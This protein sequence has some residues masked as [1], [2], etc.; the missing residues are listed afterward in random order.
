[1]AGN[2]EKK[3]KEYDSNVTSEDELTNVRYSESDSSVRVPIPGPSG[4]RE[5]GPLAAPRKNKS[6]EVRKKKKEISPI[7]YPENTPKKNDE[8]VPLSKLTPKRVRPPVKQDL[9][10]RLDA[11]PA[12]SEPKI[13]SGR[14]PLESRVNCEFPP[15]Q[16]ENEPRISPWLP[17]KP[18]YTPKNNLWLPA[19]ASHMKCGTAHRNRP[20]IEGK[21]TS[22]NDGSMTDQGQNGRDQEN[23][24]Q[25]V[26]EED[27]STDEAGDEFNDPKKEKRN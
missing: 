13:H 3:E 15:R 10:A 22:R 14:G 17:W 20:F 11:V 19:T 5:T 7:K 4:I 2:E 1:M 18:E 12:S 23:E 16:N 25:R 26:S 9:R 8:D 6:K 24:E 21:T 27:I